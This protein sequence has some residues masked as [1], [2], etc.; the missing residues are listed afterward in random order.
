MPTTRP[1]GFTLIELMI[2]VAILAIL[3]AIAIPAYQDYTVR[4]Q[5]SEGV[6]LAE[7]A[8]TAIWDHWANNGVLPDDNAAAGLTAAEDIRGEYVEEVRIVQG[9]IVVTFGT[10]RENASISG[11]TFILSPSGNANAASMR[12]ECD[13][14]TVP[15]RYRPSRCR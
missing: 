2:V 14:G 3:M 11:R 15:G 12:W 8:K 5:V 6:S 1:G 7:A 13:G 9:D 10:G 4:A